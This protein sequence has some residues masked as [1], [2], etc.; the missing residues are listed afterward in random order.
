MEG[1]IVYIK[2]DGY[3]RYSG[4]TAFIVF[5]NF[6]DVQLRTVPPTTSL[7]PEGLDLIRLWYVICSNETIFTLGIGT[8]ANPPLTILGTPSSIA[9]SHRPIADILLIQCMQA[10]SLCSCQSYENI[11]PITQASDET[12]ASIWSWS[13]MGNKAAH[14][15]LE[16][17]NYFAGTT[18][19][20]RSNNTSSTSARGRRQD[21]TPSAGNLTSSPTLPS[22]SPSSTHPMSTP[23]N[24]LL[25]PSNHL[26]SP[27]NHPKHRS[28]PSP[29]LD[30][31]NG[32]RRRHAHLPTPSHNLRILRPV[33]FC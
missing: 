33:L 17:W 8:I 15:V 30:L 21:S 12:K 26:L 19:E 29:Q 24:H 27:S 16:L 6:R 1:I 28:S 31:H 14:R 25:S 20:L 4:Y 7:L 2:Y 11:F 5:A 13:V 3:E 23:S 32:R 9:L 10:K 18:N 22:L